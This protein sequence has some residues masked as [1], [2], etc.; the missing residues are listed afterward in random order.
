[1]LWLSSS[2]K[3]CGYNA[4]YMLTGGSVL[5]EFYAFFTRSPVEINC[6][7][8]K[9]RGLGCQDKKDSP[10]LIHRRHNLYLVEFGAYKIPWIISSPEPTAHRWAYSIG[11]HP[12]F[13]RRRRRLS[14]IINIFKQHLLWSHEANSC[15]ISHI[16]STGKGN[17]LY[18]F[19]S[20]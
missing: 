16:A 14:I 1:M 17:E 20:K 11:R 6:C 13:V 8:S 12:S 3:I 2:G 10:K 15:Y 18:Y 19:L 5:D 4:T 9:L 7:N